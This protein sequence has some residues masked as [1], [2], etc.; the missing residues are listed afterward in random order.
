MYE[1]MNMYG[2]AFSRV[3]IFFFE[4]IKGHLISK[5][6]FEVVD[7]LQKANEWIRFY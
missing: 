5:L 2:K 1:R 6:F 4:A 3:F 7:F